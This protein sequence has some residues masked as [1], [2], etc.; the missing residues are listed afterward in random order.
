MRDARDSRVIPED[1]EQPAHHVGL[2][3]V[4]GQVQVELRDVHRQ[5]G[6]GEAIQV[7]QEDFGIGALVEVRLLA[8][9]VDE[10]ALLQQVDDVEVVGRDAVFDDH[11]V[12]VE[13]EL[14]LREVLARKL[15]GLDH[16]V[17]AGGAG[18]A[19]RLAVRRRRVQR[20]IEN[21][22]VFEIRITRGYRRHPFL[23][24][25][26]LFRGGQRGDPA[27]LLLAPEQRVELELETVRDGGL[28]GRVERGPVH[29]VAR[30]FDAA[31]F[32]RVLRA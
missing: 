17:E 2:V 13:D 25:L 12:L 21:L 11:V 8:D 4:I 29:G 9:A 22:D 18:A 15:E 20:F 24:F 26:E 14:G 3:R 1:R 27:R 28:I 5:P 10:L 7:A 30:A 23:D 16:P 31:P 6:R 32:A 19:E